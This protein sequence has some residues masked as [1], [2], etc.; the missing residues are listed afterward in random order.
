[1]TLRLAGGGW[2]AEMRPEIGGSL[3]SLTFE[4]REVLRTMPES[5]A[6]PLEAACF[7]LA[8]YCNRI[9]DGRFGFAGQEVCLPANFPPERHSLHGLSWQRPWRVDSEAANKCVLTDDYDGAGPWPWAY[10]AEQRVR[11]GDW[12]CAI[13]LVLTSLGDAAMPAGI[14]LHPYFRRRA[15][16]RIRFAADHVLL[17]DAQTLPTGV[18][19]PPAHFG[20]FAQGAS[21][22]PETIDHCFAGWSGEVLIEDEFGTITM[23]ASGAPH[24]HLYAPADGSALCCEPV[25][26]T[27]DALNR[28]PGEMIMLPPGCSATLQMQISAAI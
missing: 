15:G 19:A 3:A 17:S 11:L 18:S 28:A 21:L 27:P 13:S 8:P 23:T 2:Q 24:L 12:G 1:V 20:D 5:S 14:G 6:S 7:P 16:A 10:R 9:R 26:H 22:P 4:G 25:S